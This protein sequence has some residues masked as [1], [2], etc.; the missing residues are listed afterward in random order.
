MYCLVA[1][2]AA[3]V[4]PASPTEILLN[5]G[6]RFIDSQRSTVMLGT[7]QPG[8][9]FISD[10]LVHRHKTESLR[11][12]C[13]PIRDDGH[14][15]HR[16]ECRKKIGEVVLRCLKGQISYVNFLSQFFLPPF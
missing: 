1:A 11:T 8:D 10:L 5:H 9:R 2:S 6:A 7:I 16:S 3:A 12:P 13:V 14:C 15:F 4:T